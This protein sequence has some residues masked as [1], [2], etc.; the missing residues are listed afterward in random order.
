MKTYKN[1]ITGIMLLVSFMFNAGCKTSQNSGSINNNTLNGHAYVDL[2]LPSG[3]LWATCNVGAKKP[4][5]YGDYFAWGETQ[6]KANYSN[7]TYKYSKA[8]VHGG[9]TKYSYNTEDGYNG[10]VD[11]LT[12]LE[13]IDDAATV[14][15]GGSWR[16]PTKDECEELLT[17]TSKKV[18]TIHKIKGMRLTGPNGQSIFLPATGN[19]VDTRL[20]HNGSEG[21]YWSG[22]LYTVVSS[23][24]SFYCSCN[25]NNCDMLDFTIRE[26][27]HAIRPVYSPSK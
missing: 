24:W 23:A 16:T 26:L 1:V 22:S 15:W 7:T 25:S 20:L 3:T 13:Q 9:Y 8:K 12:I 17:Y 19:R 14:N 27:G 10:Y 11:K 21:S 2:G 5:D 6:P 18:E 4:E